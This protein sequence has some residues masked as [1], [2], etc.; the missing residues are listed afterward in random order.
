MATAQA[1]RPAARRAQASTP[2]IEW[3]LGGIGV[4]LLLACIAFLVHEGLTDGE[5]PGAITASV[6]DIRPAGDQHVV[7]VR[8]HNSGSQTLSNVRVSAYL[9]DGDREVERA[10]TMLDYVPGKSTEEGGFYFQHDPRELRIEIRPEGF[11]KP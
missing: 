3:I 1:K 2:L 4:G 10:T 9:L 11:Q 5:Q 7:L 6:V 8:I